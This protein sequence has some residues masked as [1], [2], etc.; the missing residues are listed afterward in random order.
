MPINY[1]RMRATATRLVGGNGAE[2]AVTRKGI[3]K[4]IGGKEVKEPDLSFTSTGVRTDYRPGEIDGTVI[5]NG[6]VRIVF[7][8]DSELRVGD[9]VSIDG[10]QYRII[11]PNPVKPATLL[12]CYRAQLRA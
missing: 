9:M 2:F 4:V 12:L 5:L 3:V 7:T 6:D 11:N 1:E 10:K 8:A